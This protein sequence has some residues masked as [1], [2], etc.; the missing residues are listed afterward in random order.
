[1]FNGIIMYRFRGFTVFRR[2]DNTKGEQELN[3][4][5]LLILKFWQDCEKFYK[6]PEIF[7]LNASR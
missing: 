2:K 5:N 7:T 3:T 1:M 4:P 6:T